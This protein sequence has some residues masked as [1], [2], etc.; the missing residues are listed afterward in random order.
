MA[1]E[2]FTHPSEAAWPP[3]SAHHL[4]IGAPQSGKTT[5]A[6]NAFV[7]HVRSHG[8]RRA[9]FLT[10][11]R[12]RAAALQNVI[13][14][15]FGGTTG[16]L[17]VRT[18]ASLAFGLL[19]QGASSRGE[20]TPTLITG[21]EQD[22][23]LAELIAG[24]L[25]DGVDPGWP[26]EITPQVLSMRAFRDELRDL[27]MRAAEAGLDGPALTAVGQL[28]RRPEWVAAGRLLTEYTAVTVLGEITPDRGARYDAATI[29]DRAVAQIASTPQ[30]STFK[31][32]V[33][34]DYQDATLA[35]SRLLG[36]LARGGAQLL[37]ASNPDTGVQGFRGGL[38][39]LRPTATRPDGSQAGAFGAQMPV[40]TGAQ[41]VPP[42]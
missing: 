30:L 10:P 38:P 2:P 39:A 11:T 17:L 14:H 18:P 28:H 24:H 26:A 1:V 19:R 9:V 15:K 4:V 5:L 37:L 40:R 7:D 42:S 12:Q 33:H 27:L 23:I 41:M 16:Q 31:A 36:A 3:G 35:T 29:L 21:P 13:A 8:P 6:V 20:P 34:D 22:Q 32:L 25:T